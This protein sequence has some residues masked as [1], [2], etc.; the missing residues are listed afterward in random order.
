MPAKK[1]EEIKTVKEGTVILLSY[2]IMN[3]EGRIIEARTPENPAEFLVGH[4]QILKALEKKILGET[5][6]FKGGFSFSAKEAHGEYRKELVVEMKREQFP[7]EIEIAKG[8]KFESH[9]P[10]GEAVALHVLEFDD[11]VVLVDGNHPLAGE[12]LTFDISILEIRDAAKEEIAR[13]QV[14]TD[15]E[16]KN[17]TVH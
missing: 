16:A 11:K 2:S 4:G 13:G 12:D 14:L 6:G 5:E 1:I 3:G 9:G 8:M 7:E 17:K 10:K 15:M